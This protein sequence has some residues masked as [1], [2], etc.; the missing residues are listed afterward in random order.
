MKH[1]EKKGLCGICSAGCWI[2]ASYDNKE[3]IT[4][5]R[6]DDDSQMGIT[7]KIG[8]HSPEIIKDRLL[9]PMKRKGGKGNQ[10][11]IRISWE[12]AYE[13][14]AEKL[15]LIKKE[16]GPEAAAIYTGVGSFEQSI[17]DIF[18]PRGVA[19]SSASSVLFPF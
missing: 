17:C 6:A 19:V 14:I 11:F 7:C 10:N 15:L 18:Q 12:E 16:H 3:R 8:E 13:R 5:I 4:G 2:V 1:S 9:H